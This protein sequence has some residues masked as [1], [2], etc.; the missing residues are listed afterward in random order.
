ML[1][2]AHKQVRST[3]LKNGNTHPTLDMLLDE[4]HTNKNGMWDSVENLDCY[5]ELGRQL[6]KRVKLVR[7]TGNEEPFL[8]VLTTHGFRLLIILNTKAI[9][10]LTKRDR[11]DGAAAINLVIKSIKWESVKWSTETKAMG[12]KVQKN[13][14]RTIVSNYF[15]VWTMILT[16]L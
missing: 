13:L 9:I 5:I 10:K 6:I 8:A 1:T 2:T 3:L 11:K 14:L 7:M 12:T 4:I 16:L 15:S